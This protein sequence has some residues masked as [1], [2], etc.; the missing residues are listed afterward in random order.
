MKFLSLNIVF[1]L[2]T[3]FFLAFS[4]CSNDRTAGDAQKEAVAGASEGLSSESIPVFDN[5]DDMAYVFSQ[6]TDTVYV[7]NF[8]ATWC[9]PCIAEMPYFER[10]A[11]SFSTEKMK[12]V[13]V[14]LD[15][16]EQLETRLLPYLEKNEMPGE[17]MLLADP[18]ANYW[19]DKVNPEWGGA[20]PVTLVYRGDRRE[21]TGRAFAS[22]EELERIVKSML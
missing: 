7:V 16:K 5:F 11:K 17:V 15:F 4:G 13:L 21:F 18:N 8:W 12:I 6:S 2:S 3:L 1:P 19:I 22:Y 9:K 20:I 14:S 10:L